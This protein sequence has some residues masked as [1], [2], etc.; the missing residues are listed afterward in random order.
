MSH[1][2]LRFPCPVP[3]WGFRVPSPSEGS[4]AHPLAAFPCPS[5]SRGAVP[6][7]L[8]VPREAEP[9]PGAGRAGLLARHNRAQ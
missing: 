9:V 3:G 5:L 6:C 7:P 2:Q 4:A 1:P 8:G